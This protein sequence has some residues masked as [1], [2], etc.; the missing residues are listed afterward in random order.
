MD[1]TQ[2]KPKTL[3]DA[4][5]YFS[6]PDNCLAYMTRLRFPD[7]VV[8]CPRCGRKDVVYLKNQRKWQCKSVHPKRQ[9]SAKVG[10]VMEDSPIPADKWLLAV[11][12]MGNCKNGVS[13]YEI[14]KAIGVTQKSAWFMLHRIRLGL[15]LNARNF[16]TKSKIGGPENEVEVDE[17]FVGGRKK[18]MHLDKKLRYEDRGGSQGKTIVQGCLDRTSRQVRAKVV[19]NL[20]REV[21]QKEILGAVKYG[22]KVYTDSAMAY[23]Q[24]MQWRFVHDVSIRLKYSSYRTYT[25]NLAVRGLKSSSWP[26]S[27]VLPTVVRQSRAI[28]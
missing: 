13:S 11:W 15:S 16:G 20:T 23:D 2:N 3:Q 24:G 9:F 7:G 14:A 5:L 28:A 8:Y 26:L 17:T 27:F 12:M 10:T 22:T 1:A 19:P 25:Q 4:I 18:N 6:N 21:L